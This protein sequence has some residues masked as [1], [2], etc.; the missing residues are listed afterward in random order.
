MGACL[1]LAIEDKFGAAWSSGWAGDSP[2]KDGFADN[3]EDL[4]GS[5]R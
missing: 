3:T 2:G 4:D 1:F 5:A